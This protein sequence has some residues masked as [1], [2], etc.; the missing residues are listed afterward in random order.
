MSRKKRP[1]RVCK[2]WYR[3][4]RQGGHA[5]KTCGNQT[6]QRE[7]K[8][9]K[10]RE[11]RKA[12]RATCIEDQYSKRL[13]TA[14]LGKRRPVHNLKYPFQLGREVMGPEG[15]VFIELILKLLFKASREV[16]QVEVIANKG[17]PG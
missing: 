4:S 6:C 9:K 3:P 11:W 7:W 5:Q 8:I 15:T 1:C 12:N 17:D 14:K 16:K 10:C 13:E 2:K